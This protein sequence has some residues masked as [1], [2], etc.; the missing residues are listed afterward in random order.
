MRAWG[1]LIVG[2]A[3]Q[4]PLRQVRADFDGATLVV[5]QAYSDQIADAAL[6]ARTFVL[7]F[8]LDRMTWIKPS[9][10]WMMY[11]CGWATK[12]GQERVLAIRISREGFEEALGGACLS[13]FDPDVYASHE[14]WRT[15]LSQS[16]VRVQWDPE[17]RPDLTPLPWR[18]FQVGLRGPAARSYVDEWI[19]EISDITPLVRELRHDTARTTAVTARERP[20]P[21]AQP[22]AERIGVSH[23]VVGGNGRSRA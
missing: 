22:I 3:D 6:A 17:R 14:Q 1:E 2:G 7:P 12:P 4:P 15:L 10:L 18:S 9:F 21:L 11:R 20:Y 13:H 8:K 16:P 23:E 5:Y 19:T